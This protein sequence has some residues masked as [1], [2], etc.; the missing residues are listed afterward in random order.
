MGPKIGR[1]LWV[2]PNNQ[3]LPT[4]PI[5]HKKTTTSPLLPVYRRHCQ[6]DRLARES[7][8]STCD[9]APLRCLSD[10]MFPQ[11]CTDNTSYDPM[12]RPSQ[13]NVGIFRIAD[14]GPFHSKTNQKTTRMTNGIILRGNKQQ[15][16]NRHCGMKSAVAKTNN[17]SRHSKKRK[18][19]AK[20]SRIYLPSSPIKANVAE[21]EG[22]G[23]RWSNGE[24]WS[25]RERVKEGK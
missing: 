14:T 5:R 9:V 10:I 25:A 15:T 24:R 23:E 1:S 6:S 7:T 17:R 2:L 19:N 12:R 4:P 16:Q 8:T 20:C 21:G 3:T 13:A 11:R 18:A 22:A